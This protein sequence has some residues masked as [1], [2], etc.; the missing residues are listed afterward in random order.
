MKKLLVLT[1]VLGLISCSNE[2][3]LIS[4]MKSEFKKYELPNFNDP[5]SFE[6]VDAKIVDTTFEK[7][8]DS[9]HIE[10]YYD[11]VE[12][13]KTEM[14]LYKSFYD[15]ESKEYYLRD[16]AESNK[17]SYLEYKEKYENSLREKDSALKENSKIPVDKIRYINLT[18]KM[19]AKNA[20][21][22]LILKEVPVIYSPIGDTNTK[23]KEIRHFSF[24]YGEDKLKL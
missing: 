13:Y 6:E 19:R 21:G 15:R 8:A 9:V 14:E 1:M 20:M 23:T 4:D 16:L 7:H 12:R 5:K 3:G 11:G 18:Y 17:Q 24:R 2:G 10:F 22:G